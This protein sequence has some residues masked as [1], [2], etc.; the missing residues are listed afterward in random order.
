MVG[1]AWVAFQGDLGGG[2]RNFGAGF[3]RPQ[4]VQFGG[5][6]QHAGFNG[7][8]GGDLLRAQL[9][10]AR[11]SRLGLCQSGNIES[12]NNSLRRA[13]RGFKGAYERICDA[14]LPPDYAP[15]PH[16]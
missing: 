4:R 15:D 10:L 3:L 2:N 7:F 9:F 8:R 12:Q 6:Y 1:A 11:Q 14:L 5:I 13:G 16:C